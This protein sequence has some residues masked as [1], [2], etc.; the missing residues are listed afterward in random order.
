MSRAAL[1]ATLPGTAC[2][3]NLEFLAKLE[4]IW[5]QLSLTRMRS[6][7][8][9]LSVFLCHDPRAPPQLQTLA[10]INNPTMFSMPILS[11]S[12]LYPISELLLSPSL[13]TSTARG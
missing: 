13:S 6:L 11:S 12:L 4:A 8:K 2:L 3:C 1:E 5:K 10:G 9:F 7:G